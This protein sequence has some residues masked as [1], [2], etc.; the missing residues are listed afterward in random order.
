MEIG[1]YTWKQ[2]SKIFYVVLI[3]L[4]GGCYQPPKQNT[5]ITFP[6]T[7]ELR[8]GNLVCRL[9]NG[10][11][12]NYFRKYASKEKK[13]SHIGL[14]SIEND[15][16]FVYHSEASE[17]TGVGFV[18][19]EPLSLFLNGIKTFDFFNINLDDTIVNGI[20]ENSRN[21]HLI[22]T[23]FDLEFDS[24]EDDKLYCTEL[25]AFSINKATH[26]S[27]IKPSLE[28]NHKKLY[29]L[30]DIYSNEIMSKITFK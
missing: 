10:Y 1:L 16:I 21:Y 8:S 27:T 25:L 5:T 18:K 22:H 4:L 11:F 13:Y 3:I 28:L 19:K 30:D 24:F 14:V 12:S 20:V 29:S 9:G 6:F 2:R 15:T 17:L 7:K 23:P 26:Y